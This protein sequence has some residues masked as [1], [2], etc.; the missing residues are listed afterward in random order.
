[1]RGGEGD[2]GELALARAAHEYCTPCPRG[3]LWRFLAPPAPAGSEEGEEPGEPEDKLR[4][5]GAREVVCRCTADEG[6][7]GRPGADTSDSVQRL[8]PSGA[9][10]GCGCVGRGGGGGARDPSLCSGCEEEE[11]EE[12]EEKDPPAVEDTAPT[13][14]CAQKWCRAEA[15]ASSSFG[16]FFC[17]VGSSV[18][19]T[20][21]STLPMPWRLFVCLFVCW[22]AP[23]H[24]CSLSL[25]SPFSPLPTRK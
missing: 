15:A 21:P 25:S 5:P 14:R 7:R 10:M 24:K 18:G 22:W 11:D 13:S 17:F 23:C 3:H 2:R 6:A 4:A 9:R 1:M 8:P 20:C 12:E 16:C 19:G